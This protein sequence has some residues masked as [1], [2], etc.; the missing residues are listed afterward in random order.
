MS[1]I[2]NITHNFHVTLYEQ[3]VTKEYHDIPIFLKYT[4]INNKNMVAVRTSEVEETLG[5]IAEIM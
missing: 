3:H 4:D 1:P 5:S 2:I